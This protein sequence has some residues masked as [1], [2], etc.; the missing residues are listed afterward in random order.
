M[1]WLR[2]GYTDCSQL[3]QTALT[4]AVW[5]CC[6]GRSLCYVCLYIKVIEGQVRDALKRK[7]EARGG[8][9]QSTSPTDWLADH[10]FLSE[11]TACSVYCTR[12]CVVKCERIHKSAARWRACVMAG[13]R[14]VTPLGRHGCAAL[15]A[16]MLVIN[17]W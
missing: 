13:E 8:R 7:W 2:A 10:R 1:N 14:H 3:T 4:A 16:C 15:L 11:T 17:G 6:C 9:V 5:T 12:W